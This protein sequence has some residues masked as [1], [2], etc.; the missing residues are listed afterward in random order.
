MR[1]K[2]IYKEAGFLPSCLMGEILSKT[3]GTSDSTKTPLHGSAGCATS[4]LATIVFPFT[5]GMG[6]VYAVPQIDEYL[7]PAVEEQVLEERL[8]RP[9]D[10]S[11]FDIGEDRIKKV[12]EFD[13]LYRETQ[14]NWDF[15]DQQF[16]LVGLIK[17]P[18]RYFG[19]RGG[20]VNPLTHSLLVYYN[21]YGCLTDPDELVH[22]L[23][24]LWHN[25]LGEKDAFEQQWYGITGTGYLG[26]NPVKNS[27]C[28]VNDF[29]PYVKAVAAPRD[30]A[31]I[32]IDEHIAET[33]RLVYIL[34]NTYKYGVS[35]GKEHG[36]IVKF[37]VGAMHLPVE[38][39]PRIE[40]QIELLV[41]YDFFSEQEKTQALRNLESLKKL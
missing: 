14:M 33:T 27:F 41:V 31:A 7:Y 2:K 3:K 28:R 4:V 8:D 22:E 24:H 40:Q 35:W 18:R 30:Y 10:L 25:E 34:Q 17:L 39:I 1:N 20:A 9:V 32:N 13:K 16:S 12:D 38:I 11:I 19:T 26:C 37:Q 5:F 21:K 23:A 29:K 15:F 36:E 6:L